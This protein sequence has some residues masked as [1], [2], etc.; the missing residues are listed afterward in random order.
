MTHKEIVHTQINHGETPACPYVFEMEIDSGIDEALDQ[1]Y[2][3]ADWRARLANYI[4]KTPSMPDGRDVWKPGPDY[5]TDFFGT[6]WR[7]DLKPV[8]V[9]TPALPE[10]TLSRYRFPEIS[11]FTTP[12]WKHDVASYVAEHKDQFVVI[13]TGFGLFE[14][15]WMLRGFENALTDA[16]LDPGFYA[17]LLSAIA[18]EH[19]SPLLDHLIELPVDGIMFGD[20]WG[21]QRGVLLGPDR[22]RGMIKPLYKKL[23]RKVKDAGKVVLNHVCG[24]ILDI[25]PDLVDIELDVLE[26]L[27][28]EARGMDPYRIKKE[29]GTNLALW[30]GLGSQSLIPFGTP[31]EIRK[32]INHLKSSMTN[33]GGYIL[34]CAKALQQGTPVENAAAIFEE[35]TV[36]NGR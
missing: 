19:M 5:R 32:E 14:R 34:S 29:F 35:F 12:E 27:Q 18:E 16:A 24:S 6:V 21:D 28:V 3:D 25:L 30:G 31:D 23:Y 9:E 4:G 2:G 26:S 36:D 13:Y 8:H 33:Q 20:D 11:R 17:S 10:P 15:S 22:W 7:L 1:Y